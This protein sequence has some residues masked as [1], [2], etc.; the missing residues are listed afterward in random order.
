[1]A[2]PPIKRN[3]LTVPQ[4]ANRLGVAERTVQHW[5]TTGQ[6]QAEQIDPG[7]KRTSWIVATAE[8]ERFERERG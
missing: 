3:F 2:Q 1:M 4:I 7:R 6:L 8:V 5:I